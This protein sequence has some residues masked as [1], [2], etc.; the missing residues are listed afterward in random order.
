M[1]L[2]EAPPPPPLDVVVV[3]VVGGVV[4]SSKGKVS[5]SAVRRASFT[6]LTSAA[7]TQRRFLA[8]S[9]RASTREGRGG[10]FAAQAAC[11]AVSR[12]VVT[13]FQV[14]RRQGG[15]E[16]TGALVMRGSEA[17]ASQLAAAAAR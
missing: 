15:R 10:R 8:S 14:A 2:S 3:V 9:A 11:R 5:M 7:A 1:A 4:S 6:P 17:G 16:A 13:G 12:A